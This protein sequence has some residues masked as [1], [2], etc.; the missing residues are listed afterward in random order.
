[1]GELFEER[2]FAPHGLC[3][4]LGQLHGAQGWR[5]PPVAA[6][7]IHTRLDQTNGLQGVHE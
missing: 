5:Q 1:M 7:N 2:V 6:Q 4:H 3:H